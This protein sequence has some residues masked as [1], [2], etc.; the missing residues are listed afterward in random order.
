M[1][2]EGVYCTWTKKVTKCCWKGAILFFGQ[3]KLNRFW[4]IF[5]TYLEQLGNKILSGGV[6]CIRKKSRKK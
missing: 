6:N 1:L 2:S 3:N 5:F 4:K